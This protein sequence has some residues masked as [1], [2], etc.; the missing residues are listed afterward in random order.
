MS[1]EFKGDERRDP[2]KLMEDGISRMRGKKFRRRLT[3]IDQE[4]RSRERKTGVTGGDFQDLIVEK[5]H[6]DAE[7][8]KLEGKTG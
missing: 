7:I 1:P 6:I 8:R 3:E 2:R 4:L 5:M